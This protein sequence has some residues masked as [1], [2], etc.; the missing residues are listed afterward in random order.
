MKSIDLNSIIYNE[1]ITKDDILSTI[2]QEQIYSHYLGEEIVHKTIICSPLRN[3]NVPSFGFYYRR[4]GSGVLMFNDLATHDSGDCFVFVCKLFRLGFKEALWKIAYDFGLSDVEVDAEKKKVLTTPKVVDTTPIKIGIKS[5]KWQQRDK[6]FWGSFGITKETLMK[7][8]VIPITHVFF[9]NSPK[10]TDELAYAYLE[11]KDN[12]TSYKIYQPFSKR[13]KWINN[14]NSS[15]HQ[16]YSQLPKSGKVLIITKSLKDVMSLHDVAN[17]SSVGL[18]S[19]SIMM[20][21][22]VMDEYKSRFEHVICLFDND[23]AG[24]KLSKEFSDEYQIPYFMMPKIK[25]VTDFSDLVKEIGV[26]KSK[27]DMS[28]RILIYIKD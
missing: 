15:V 21:H 6:K 7:F 4:D 26:S 18:Q 22:S 16:G 12:H 11:Q 23:K 14:A 13:H 27:I 2:S 1:Q 8:N 20:K 10:K 3:D 17:L 24:M 25:N 9:N 5:R 28:K 19:E